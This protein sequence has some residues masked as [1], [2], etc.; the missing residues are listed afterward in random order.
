MPESM[1]YQM[2]WSNAGTSARR[3]LS[4]QFPARS[5][6]VA[7][8]R[9]S[10]VDYARP[11]GMADVDDIS[12][13]VSEAV[14]NAVRHAYRVHEPGTIELRAELLVPDTL[15]VVVNDDGDGMSPHPESPGLGL[16]L[17][18]IGSVTTGLEIECH[19]PHGTSVRMR[20]SLH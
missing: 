9:H 3:P 5:E 17:S 6:S 20:F 1:P 19:R 10:I 2:V 7:A 12:L 13:A 16:G 4:L 8:A 18:L 14:G 15:G 11:L